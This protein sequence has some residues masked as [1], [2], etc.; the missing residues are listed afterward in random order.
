VR[1]VRFVAWIV[2]FP[3]AGLWPPVSALARAGVSFPSARAPRVFF[4][5]KRLF[6]DSAPYILAHSPFVCKGL[7]FP[8]CGRAVRSN[9]KSMDFYLKLKIF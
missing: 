4:I 6:L 1:E 7:C 2:S 5:V 8:K 9:W 3:G